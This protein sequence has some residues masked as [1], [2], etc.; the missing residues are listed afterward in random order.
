MAKQVNQK[1]ISAKINRDIF[2]LMELYCEKCNIKRNALIR[3]HLSN[4]PTH[5]EGGRFFCAIVV[6]T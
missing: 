1:A 6:K 4:P 5:P 2:A 3:R